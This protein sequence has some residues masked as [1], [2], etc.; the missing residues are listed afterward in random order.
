LGE[1]KNSRQ[2]RRKTTRPH[3]E[4]PNEEGEPGIRKTR[5]LFVYKE[6]QVLGLPSCRY[7]RLQKQEPH[8]PQK[9]TKNPRQYPNQRRQTPRLATEYPVAIL[10]VIAQ[11]LK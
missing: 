11:L 4:V 10:R 7:L 1:Y 3:T 6:S 2:N 9:R 5:S 8:Y